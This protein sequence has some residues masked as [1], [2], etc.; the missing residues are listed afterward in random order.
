VS[1]EITT[2]HACSC[3]VPLAIS[4]KMIAG[5]TRPAI[6]AT[7]GTSARDQLVSSPIANSRLTSSPTVKKKIAMS[8]SLTSACSVKSS[9]MS[10]TPTV[11]CVSHRAS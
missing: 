10:P 3:P 1:V 7:T 4:R 8:A 11:S 9:V 2:P 5:T 6:A